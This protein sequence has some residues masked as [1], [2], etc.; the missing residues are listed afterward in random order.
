M[1]MK[2]VRAYG[3]EYRGIAGYYLL[4]SD[5]WRLDALRWEAET[6]MLKTLRPASSWAQAAGLY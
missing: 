6:S 4:A 1:P 5:V 3:A 2:S